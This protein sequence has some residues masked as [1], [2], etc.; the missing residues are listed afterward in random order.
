MRASVSGLWPFL[1]CGFSTKYI[2]LFI[3][4]L[5]SFTKQINYMA[6][7]ASTVVTARIQISQGSVVVY[8]RRGGNFCDGYSVSLKICWIVEIG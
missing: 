5:L 6:T 3:Q 4:V 7:S 2:H 1:S 8:S